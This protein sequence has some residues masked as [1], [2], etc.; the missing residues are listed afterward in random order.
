MAI[1]HVDIPDGER[2]EPKG[3]SSAL[4]DTVYV[5]NGLGSG[6]WSTSKIEGQSAAASGAIPYKQADGGILWQVP[7]TPSYC[8]IDSPEAIR[9]LTGSTEILVNGAY[10]DD[11]TNGDFI[12]DGGDTLT[13]NKTG[14]YYTYFTINLKPQSSLSTSNEV[15]EARLKINDEVTSPFRI[16]PI[17]ITRNSVADDPFIIT[18]SRIIDFTEGDVVTMTLKNLASTRTYKVTVNFGMFRIA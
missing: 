10:F 2:H 17:T 9:S 6:S 15:V 13:I 1:E 16:I 12:L 7:V 3:I 14:I 18:G 4:V 11:Y 8:E 5:S